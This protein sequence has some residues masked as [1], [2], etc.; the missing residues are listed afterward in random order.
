MRRSVW[1]LLLFLLAACTGTQSPR[2]PRLLFVTHEQ[3]GEHRAVLI[4][5]N[6]FAAAGEERLTY[7]AA[8]ELVLPG[9]PLALDVVDR[10]G[11]RSQVVLLLRLQPA[12]YSAV[13]LD[14][15]AIE[16]GTAGQLQVLRSV[17]LASELGGLLP[18]PADLCLV[19]L[20]V[21][22]DGTVLGL[23]NNPRA[24]GGATDARGNVFILD[25][26]TGTSRSLASSEPLAEAGVFIRQTRDDDELYFLDEAVQ[27]V[28]LNRVELPDG[29]V[30]QLQRF[31][32]GSDSP[33]PLQL[34]F[35]DG[36]FVALQRDRVRLLRD[37]SSSSLSVPQ[38]RSVDLVIS[39]PAGD[40]L[41]ALLVLQS[42]ASS[43]LLVYGASD[44]DE[45]E[46][47]T[48][49][50]GVSDGTVDPYQLWVYLL[51]PGG[52][53]ILDLLGLLEG[54]GSRP[55]R[56]SLPAGSLG[57]PGFITWVDGILP[58]PQP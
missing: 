10:A 34:T 11:S 25:I 54:S 14:V 51:R 45:P 7:L 33:P 43:R 15:E 36:A 30:E 18:D 22:R 28:R 52:V 44:S 5:E 39:D 46:E 17:D 16:P 13:W 40:Y 9:E 50:S 47:V 56:V 57:T 53:D 41:Q 38:E 49:T 29:P 4:E 26:G 20:Q 21:S 31:A 12:G 19:D 27:A 8:T 23:Y 3:G 6:A 42:G 1:L 2:E 58:P 55:A 48:L 32:E 35:T 37:G 24:C